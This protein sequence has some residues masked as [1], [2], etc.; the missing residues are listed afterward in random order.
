[1]PL[2]MDSTSPVH[3]RAGRQHLVTSADLKIQS[4]YNTYLNKDHPPTPIC[5]PSS[6]AALD[7]RRSARPGTSACLRAR[8]EKEQDMAFSDTYTDQ[9]ANEKLAQSRAP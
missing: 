3:P 4:P 2:Q 7:S 9:L 1:M 5:I 6:T 8:P